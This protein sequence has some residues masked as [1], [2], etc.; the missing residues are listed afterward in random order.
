[1]KEYNALYTYFV[2]DFE[3]GTYN[4]LI[5]RC[6][7]VGETVRSYRIRLIDVIQR[8]LPGEC[9]WVRKKSIFRSMKD[10]VSGECDNYHIVVRDDSCKTCL[11]RCYRKNEINN[12]YIGSP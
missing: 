9:L 3:R 6:V 7:I 10:N 2:K 5:A 4:R 1:M 11:Q 8:R 12:N